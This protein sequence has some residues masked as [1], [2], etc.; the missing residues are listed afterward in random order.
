VFKIGS[1]LYDINEVAISQAIDFVIDE[2]DLMPNG[3]SFVSHT[4]DQKMVFFAG[5][6]R[7]YDQILIEFNIHR[8]ST[9]FIRLISWP[10]SILILLTLTIFFLPPSAF[11]RIIYGQSFF[12]FKFILNL[13]ILGGLLLVCQ[14]ILLAIFAFYIPKRLGTRWPWMGRTI[15]Y[16]ICLTAMTL[17]FSVFVRILSDGKHYTTKRPPTKIRTVCRRENLE[18]V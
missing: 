7:N 16:D 8:R 12:F 9:Y 5:F 15:F 4:I 13:S 11:E 14:F 17:A 18:F 6:D 1:S 3:Y 10:G 2:P